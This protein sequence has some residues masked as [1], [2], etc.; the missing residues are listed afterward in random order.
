MKVAK[1]TIVAA[2]IWHTGVV[3][4]VMSNSSLL[5][6]ISSEEETSAVRPP[7]KIMIIWR[8]AQRVI[9]WAIRS[10]NTFGSTYANMARMVTEKAKFLLQLDPCI[11]SHVAFTR[12]RRRWC[13]V[14]I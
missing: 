2:M 5:S 7:E 13:G 14:E 9:E 3:Q 4:E 1:R 10:K 11:P 6:E 12:S 8:N